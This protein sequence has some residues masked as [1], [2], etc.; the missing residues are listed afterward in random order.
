MKTVVAAV[1]GLLLAALALP[2][3]LSLLASVPAVQNA[4]AHWLAGRVSERIGT[5]VSIDRVRIDLINR[6][7]VEGFY[8]EDFGGDTLLYVPRLTAPIEDLGL[9]GGTL[10]FGRVGLTGAQLWL[11][12]SPTDGQMNISR[13]VD[14]I[15]RGPSNPESRFRMR[16]GAIEADSLTF[17]L[18]RDD[19]ERRDTG[20]DFTRLVFS[21]VHAS[22]D[23]FEMRGDT[24]RMNINSLGGTERS[25]WTVGNLEAHPLVVSRGSV[26]LSDVGIRSEGSDMR[27]P[28]IRLASADRQWADFGEFSDSVAMGITMRPSRVTSELVG[29]FV[30]AVREWGVVLDDVTL[31]T[32]GVLARFEGEIERARTLGTTFALDFTS[33]GLPLFREAHFDVRLNRLE[34]NGGDV[35]TLARSMTGDE[36]PSGL[37]TVISRLDGLT[38]TGGASGA[39]NDFAA[40]GALHTAAGEADLAA[41][42]TTKGEDRNVSMDGRLTTGR[43]DLGRALALDDL[44]TVSGVVTGTL[45]TNRVTGSTG[46]GKTIRGTVNGEIDALDFRDYTYTGMTVDGKI[47]GRK[48]ELELTARDPALEADLAAT[49]DRTGTTPLL[50]VDLDLARADLAAMQIDRT[51]S[52]SLLTGR[53]G[54]NVAGSGMDDVN[55]KVE[56]HNVAYRSGGGEAAMPL[57][58]LTAR[59]N[60]DVKTLSLTSDFADA[61]FRGR[62]GYRD[63]RAY[64]GGFLRRYIPMPGLGEATGGLMLSG[65]GDP[66]AMS[67]YSIVTVNLKNM[68]PLLDALAPGASIGRKTTG[69]FMFNPYT[70]SFSLSAESPFVEWGGVL[71]ADIEVTADNAADSLKVHVSGNDVY[72]S[73]GVVRRLE[74]HGGANRGRQQVDVAFDGR[75][76]RASADSVGYADGRVGIE[77][78][79]IFRVDVP[80][81]RL[82]ANGVVSSLPTDTMHVNFNRFDLSP[83]SRLFRG[84]GIALSGRAT[85]WLDVAALA[86]NPGIDA[87]IELR[88]MVAEGRAAPPMRFVSRPADAGG[89]RFGL[90]NERSGEHLLGGSLS[91]RGEIDAWMRLDQVDAGLLDPLLDGILENTQGVTSADLTLGGTLR[92]MRADGHIDVTSLA[93]TVAYTGV[94]YSVAGARIEVNNSVLDLPLT[95]VSGTDGGGGSGTLGMRVDLGNFRDITA[96]V[97]AHTDR[98]LVF[99]TDPGDSDAFYGRVFGT[100]SATIRSGRM[101]TRID[102]SARTDAGTQFHLPLNA[103]SNVSWAD[104]VVFANPGATV[105]TTD[106]LARKRLAYERR[107]AG[108]NAPGVAG[109][110][111]QKPLELNLTASVTP[112][113]EVHMLIDPNL[114]QGIT[115]R[116]EGVI[117]MRINPASDIFTMTGDYT[118]SSGRFEFSMMNVFNKTFEITPGSTLRWSGAPDNALLAIDASLRTRTSLLPLT[119]VTSSGLVSG[120]SVAV[121]CI[122]RLRESLSDPEITFDI[123]LPSA[124]PEQR[125]LVEGV[126]NTGELKS[127]QFLSLLT[128]GSFAADNSIT[129]Q[130]A[131]AG[132]AA[133]GAVGFD[134]L[135]NQ[136]NNFLSSDDYDIFF[137]YRPQDSFSTGEVDMGFST[138][139]WDNR[140]Q[141]EIEGNWVDDRA[142][143]SPGVN[144][145]SNLTGDVS[146]TWVIDRAGNL[147]LR[148]F[149]QTIDRRDE[150]RGL[151]ESGIGIHYKRDF[152]T[153]GDIF[154]RNNINFAP[155]AVNTN[156]RRRNS[157]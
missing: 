68:E 144:N 124:D 53:L 9:G 4:L 142:A 149:S 62:T 140:L 52:L 93:T 25:G 13:V 95:P 67:N 24:I 143:T 116:G 114:G 97:E 50:R 91:P 11:R 58:T 138:G 65:G 54:V 151:Q 42:I 85:G 141:L 37:A 66:A 135:T 134:I 120:R 147:R 107:L 127:M 100:G 26:A 29:V 122:I 109:A 148:A 128:T 1:S 108:N 125:Q 56:L 46:T 153:I 16:I 35:A 10:T 121:D 111:R 48:Y 20:V 8:V 41:R 123:S 61:E 40:T 152:N 99:D 15:R 5:T 83:V 145:A 60:A 39:L 31:S 102:I 71:A 87:D 33:R 82:T 156:K 28:S 75:V 106:V 69:R 18:L 119:G 90:V 7:G 22:L 129:G 19:R 137:R 130:G 70:G 110:R 88:E 3:G 105:D 115:G 32:R 126:M 59:S 14:S 80:G 118:I 79:S 78:L 112:A 74:L 86:G 12:K 43:F 136:L 104:F 47:D 146:L 6:V 34:S 57:V 157:K 132:V 150:N 89:V 38:L 64:L 49:L 63:M 98:M 27:L 81:Q 96:E 2:L 92:D 101:G 131:N 55:G 21:C 84:R 72:S 23:D 139:F 155:N 77:G 44:G 73:R 45:E 76:W 133:T 36:L 17:G 117:D 51:D 30:P 103:K 94:R 113:A 154:R